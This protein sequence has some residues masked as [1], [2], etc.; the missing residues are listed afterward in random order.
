MRLSSFLPCCS[1]HAVINS[2]S[3]VDDA[4][5]SKVTPNQKPAP[6]P[7]PAPAPAPEPYSTARVRALF[8][9]YR[10]TE[11]PT[12]I[13]P[14]GFQ[15]LCTDAEIPLDGALPLVLAW[16]LD[17]KE[18]AN[19]TEQEWMA[20]FKALQISSLPQLTVAL[21]D[22]EDLLIFDKQ[23]LTRTP[24]SPSISKSKR[25]VGG[26]GEEPYS[27][28]RARYWGYAADKVAA[29]QKFYQFCFALAKPEQARNIDME[30]ATAFWSVILVPRYPIM[31]DVIEFIN[32]EKSSLKGVHKD[33]WNMMWDFCQTVKPTLE[34]YEADGAWP[35]LLDE[36]VVW[37]KS[38]M[39]PANGN[40]HPSPEE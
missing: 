35:T 21:R 25:P 24:S 36:F 17:A 28:N 4:E 11:Q 10:D 34:N 38:K 31:K 29:M 2:L 22:L 37:K 7:V 27:Y 9:S 26:G 15:Q 20:G 30:T 32:Q 1:S 33:I 14:E 8:E 39:E 23:P 16:Q 12:I 18:M 40:G 19:F 13:G 6:K 5:V 3:D